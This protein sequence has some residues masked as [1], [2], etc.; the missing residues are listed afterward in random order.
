MLITAHWHT[1]LNAMRSSTGTVNGIS[2]LWL[3]RYSAYW[4][5]LSCPVRSTW[6][7][8]CTTVLIPRPKLSAHKTLTHLCVTKDTTEA[9]DNF[10][11]CSSPNI[12]NQ[13]THPHRAT[14][15]TFPSCVRKAKRTQSLE[16]F[17]NIDPPCIM[18]LL[19]FPRLWVWGFTS[20]GVL[21]CVTSRLEGRHGNA[22][23]L[24]KFGGRMRCY[25]PE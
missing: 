19:K 14:I 2:R 22:E 8:W 3:I 17:L 6:D 5:L 10:S 13:V 15:K 9:A 25:V 11:L 1:A 18:I 23:Y 16:A 20:S 21:G 7:L 4:C 12:R 24:P